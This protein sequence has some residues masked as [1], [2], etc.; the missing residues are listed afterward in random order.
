[1]KNT[2]S[3]A[4]TGDPNEAETFYKSLL[5]YDSLRFP[6]ESGG[7]LILLG[8]DGKA[9]ATIVSLPWDDVE[10]NWIPYIPVANVADTLKRIE[11]AGRGND[12][13]GHDGYGW[14]RLLGGLQLPKRLA[15]SQI[16]ECVSSQR[17]S[18]QE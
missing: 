1:M 13:Y 14:L 7:E 10:P 2:L 17:R 6:D 3:L 4:A 16:K 15:G 12:G 8:S 5:G 11:D 9:R 18:D